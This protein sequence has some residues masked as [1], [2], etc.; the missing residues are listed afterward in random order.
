M[1]S[2]FAKSPIRTG[3]LAPCSRHLAHALTFDTG[4]DS[5]RT[6]V[7]L[8]PGTGAVT[9]AI[10]RRVGSDTRVVAIEVNPDLARALA[11]RFPRVEV[12]NDYAERICEVLRDLGCTHADSI[13][14]GLPWSLIRSDQQELLMG[15]VLRCLRPQGLFSTTAYVSGKLFPAG[16]RFRRL[17]ALHFARVDTGSIVWRNLPPAVV[18][19]C[20][21]H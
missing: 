19:R 4:L 10:E 1:L 18:Y 11:A 8:G 17:L 7:E 13:I 2:A 3:A 21:K 12:V 6:V 20:R 16:R 14:S 5:A 9:A 15:A